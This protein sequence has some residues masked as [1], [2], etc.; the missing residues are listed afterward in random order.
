MEIGVI[1]VQERDEKSK[2]KGREKLKNGSSKGVEEREGG[3]GMPR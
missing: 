1:C 2:Q 3:G